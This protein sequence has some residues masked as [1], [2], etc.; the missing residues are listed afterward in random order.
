MG[1]VEGAKAQL[2]NLEELLAKLSR[3][4]GDKTMRK[5]MNWNPN[6][7]TTAFFLSLLLTML[8]S[9]V[10]SGQQKP[11]TGYAPVNGLKMYYEIH[12]SGEPVVLL[13]G[14]F[15]AISNDFHWT[16]WIGEL[17]KTR[18]VIAIEMQG[19]GRTADIKRDFS[20]DYLADDV[21]ALLDYLN[22]PSADIVGYSLGGGVALNFAIRHPN[23]VRKVVSISAVLRRDGWVKEGVD[24]LSNLTAE[25]FKGS[26]M[27]AEYKN[28][29][30]TPNEFP[31]FVKHVV[32]LVSKPYDFG[33]DKLKATK[34][35]LFF[36]FG[37]ADGVRLDHIAEMYRL[38]GGEV[39]GDMQPRSASRLAILPDT[40]HVTL[41]SRI[42]MIVPMVNNFLDAEPS[43]Q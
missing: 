23:K 43:K 26:S 20:Y 21:A 40:T 37:D 5:V 30:P 29:S 7:K 13:H 12:G 27:E 28:L 18:K 39:H 35:P 17:S 4:S 11:T 36:I 9:G 16:E 3:R 31:A 38:K 33:A 22:I 14:A 24:A 10:V 1:F 6:M 34:A 19:H 2:K 41:M 25:A 15:M 8:L 32:A 42:T